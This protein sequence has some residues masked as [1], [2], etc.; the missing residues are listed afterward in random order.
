MISLSA[1]EPALA[2]RV[3]R[4]A[5]DMSGEYGLGPVLE[6]KA[7]NGLGLA[8]RALGNAGEALDE[9]SRALRLI[10]GRIGADNPLYR[11]VYNNYLQTLGEARPGFDDEEAGAWP[12]ERARAEAAPGGTPCRN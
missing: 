7:A 3:M 8:L 11:A 2:E 4:H 6:A 9:F 5:L 10:S 1:G 12:R